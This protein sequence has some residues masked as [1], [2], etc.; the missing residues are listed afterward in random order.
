MPS[1]LILNGLQFVQIFFF[2]SGFFAAYVMFTNEM[3]KKTSAVKIFTIAFVRRYI[4][5]GSLQAVVIL[6]H[7]TWL[8]R[9]GHGPIFNKINFAEREFCRRHWWKNMLFIDNYTNVPEKCLIQTW[10]LDC[11]FWLSCFGI[12]MLLIIRSSPKLKSLIL[13][14][15]LGLSVVTTGWVTWVHKLE[16]IYIFPPEWVIL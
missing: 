15:A 13:T 1:F 11:D 4:R 3:A 10:H 16:P 2:F 9:W 5:F 8:Y 12:L 14:A 7:A 6:L